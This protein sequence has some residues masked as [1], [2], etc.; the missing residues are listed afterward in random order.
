MELRILRASLPGVGH[1][2][3]GTAHRDLTDLNAVLGGQL[4]GLSDTVVK[5]LDHLDVV[6]SAGPTSCT[7]HSWQIEGTQEGV[8]EGLSGAVPVRDI[9]GENLRIPPGRTGVEWRSHSDDALQSRQVTR[10]LLLGAGKTLQGR[11]CADEEGD[12]V[13]AHPVEHGVGVELAH[14]HHR[15]PDVKGGVRTARVQATTVEPWGH[16]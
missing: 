12:L 6:I 15:S 7:G 11:R 3:L 1:T 13:A 16:V 14:R 10:I 8:P 9:G 4:V 2:A 5:N